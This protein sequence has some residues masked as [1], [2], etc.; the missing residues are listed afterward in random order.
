MPITFEET[1]GRVEETL[2]LFARSRSRLPKKLFGEQ[3][4]EGRADTF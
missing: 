1:K 4:G 2:D 3:V